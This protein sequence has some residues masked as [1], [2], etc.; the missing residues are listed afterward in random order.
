MQPLPRRH[1]VA[2]HFPAGPVGRGGASRGVHRGDPVTAVLVLAGL[3]LT[4]TLL[5]YRLGVEVGRD[6]ARDDMAALQRMTRAL[7]RDT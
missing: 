1:L 7:G 2:C 5:G 6:Q 3:C 4:G